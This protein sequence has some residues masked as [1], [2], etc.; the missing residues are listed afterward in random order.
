MMSDSTFQVPAFALGIPKGSRP[1]D[2]LLYA[3]EPV[4]VPPSPHWFIRRGK[5]TACGFKTSGQ[6]LVTVS[7]TSACIIDASPLSLASVASLNQCGN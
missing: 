5:N 2:L 7:D 3:I 6:L 1:F 4:Q